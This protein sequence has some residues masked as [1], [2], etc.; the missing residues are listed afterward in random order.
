MLLY[1]SLNREEHLIIPKLVFCA[2]KLKAL[3]N[4]TKDNEWAACLMECKNHL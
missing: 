2:Q 1:L 4:K 3:G